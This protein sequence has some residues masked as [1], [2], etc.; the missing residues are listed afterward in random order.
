[1]SSNSVRGV[2]AFSSRTNQM[3]YP[4]STIEDA[5]PIHIPRMRDRVPLGPYILVTVMALRKLSRVALRHKITRMQLSIP[6]SDDIL[7]I[8]TSHLRHAVAKV[9]VDVGC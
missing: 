4:S 8:V 7:K 6:N 1:M 5:L 9:R 3:L 2:R